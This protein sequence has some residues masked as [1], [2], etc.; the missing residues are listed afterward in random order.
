MNVDRDLLADISNTN[1]WRAKCAVQTEEAAEDLNMQD[2]LPAFSP[3]V[4]DPMGSLQGSLVSAHALHAELDKLRA[5]NE[6]LEDQLHDLRQEQ[7]E[8]NKQLSSHSNP[9]QK[10]QYFKRI[11][12]QLDL[13]KREYSKLLLDNYELEQCVKYLK[14]TAMV[15]KFIES[16]PKPVTHPRD[17]LS[18]LSLAGRLHQDTNMTPSTLME[19]ITKA[20]WK[21]VSSKAEIE[22]RIL[23]R[24]DQIYPDFSGWKSRS[25]R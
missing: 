6:A 2:L 4:H 14:A 19:L 16:G 15:E 23:Q 17:A 5:S 11:K 9:A 25:D 1:D 24:I 22:S 7:E 20:E 3:D 18:P 12:T 8:Q 13:I 10:L 21:Q